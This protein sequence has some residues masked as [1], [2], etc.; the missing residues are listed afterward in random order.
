MVSYWCPK[1]D[2]FVYIGQID[3]DSKGSKARQENDEESKQ[4]PGAA[5]NL[6]EGGIDKAGGD[7][8]MNEAN[9]S[10][11]SQIKNA[12]DAEESASDILHFGLLSLKENNETG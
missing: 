12:Y 7:I 8:V 5:G 4:V 1:M 6:L 3:D 10:L 2:C 9:E 11:E